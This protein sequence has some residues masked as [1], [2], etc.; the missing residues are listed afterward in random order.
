MG[1]TIRV[2]QNRSSS[3]KVH[4]LITKIAFLKKSRCSWLSM[5]SYQNFPQAIG[6]ASCTPNGRPNK[7]KNKHK[8]IGIKSKPLET[9]VH[10][11]N[12]QSDRHTHVHTYT[13]QTTTQNSPSYEDGKRKTK[14]RKSMGRTIHTSHK[15]NKHINSV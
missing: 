14:S 9:N 3:D 10:P 8:T 13:Q 2:G 5:C 7:T 1:A 12:P 6:F 4:C 11:S 15:Q